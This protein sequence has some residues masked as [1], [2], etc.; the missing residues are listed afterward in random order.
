VWDRRG[1][2]RILAIATLS[3]AALALAGCGEKA[4][5]TSTSVTGENMVAASGVNDSAPV[6]PDLSGGQAFANAA[7]ASDAF[8]IASS[9]LALANSSS[10]SIKK[11]AQMMIDAHTD[12]TAKLKAAVSG[13]SPAITPDPTLSAEQQAKLDAMKASSGAAFDDA[14][15]AGQ[16]EGHQKTLEALR[17]YSTTGDVA[18]LK[19][20][21]TKLVPIVAAHLNMAKSLKR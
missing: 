6:M 21:A 15:A 17:A 13:A 4:S 1:V 11:F 7:A 16:A 3:G 9:K 10:A 2:M 14:Y 12:S 8:E 5:T 20:F 19:A 18:E